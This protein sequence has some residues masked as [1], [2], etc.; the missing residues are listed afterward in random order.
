MKNDIGKLVVTLTSGDDGEVLSLLAHTPQGA[1]PVYFE[2]VQ[3]KG[4]RCGGSNKRVRVRF[5]GPKS[6]RVGRMPKKEIPH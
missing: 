4:C 2:V 5:V 3:A 1:V 6:V